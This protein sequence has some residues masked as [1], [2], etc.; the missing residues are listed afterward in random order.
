MKYF[1]KK[2]KVDKLEGGK[3]VF[4]RYSGLS[5]WLFGLKISDIIIKGHKLKAWDTIDYKQ[6]WGRQLFSLGKIKSIN[7]S[8]VGVEYFW[9]RVI[10]LKNVFF[11]LILN[12]VVFHV[13]FPGKSVMLVNGAYRGESAILESINEKKF[14]CTV[15]LNSVCII[16][17]FILM[18]L[19]VTWYSNFKYIFIV[20]RVII[21]HS[22]F[23]AIFSEGDNFHDF[24]LI[25]L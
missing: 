4:P 24:L 16:C 6:I 9:Y 19:A 7:S 3:V 20:F 2:G 10:A 18:V 17:M 13:S 23:S 15:S 25:I 21:T 14:S 5:V 12:F 1:S 22:I 11:S 8:E